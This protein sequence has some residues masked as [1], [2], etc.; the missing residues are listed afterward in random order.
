M[1]CAGGDEENMVGAHHAVARVH[2]VPSTMG[3]M[4]RCT[5]S[6][7]IT[8]WPHIGLPAILSIFNRE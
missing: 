6:R 3:K 7:D 4:S 1:E 5:P 8:H 2:R